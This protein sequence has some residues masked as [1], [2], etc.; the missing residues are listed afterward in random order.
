MIRLSVERVVAVP[1]VAV[2]Q[3]LADYHC[4]AQW[5]AGVR[6]MTVEP[7]GIAAPGAR[8]D[9]R[10]RFAGRTTRNIG[11]VLDVQTGP[12]VS[13]LRW[14]TTAG[15]DADG[16]RQVRATGADSCRVLL[17][18]RI[19][20]HGAEI[21]LAPLVRLLMAGRLRGDLARLAAL[22]AAAVPAAR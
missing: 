2:W 6:S 22:T 15:T 8:T 18:L 13:R 16:E 3:V 9:E 1:A 20:L 14:R 11:E 7:S 19:R 12:A 5:R 10:Y 21:L 4:D 17:V